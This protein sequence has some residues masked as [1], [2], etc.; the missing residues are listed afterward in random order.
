MQGKKVGW[1]DWEKNFL[2]D[3]FKLSGLDPLV[4][5]AQG[6]GVECREARLQQPGDFTVYRGH[7][8]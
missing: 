2:E 3:G 6:Q 7:P 4:N 8:S 1:I 5:E